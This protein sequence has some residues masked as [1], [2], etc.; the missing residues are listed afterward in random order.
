MESRLTY[1]FKCL[2]YLQIF[3]LNINSLFR[4]QEKNHLELRLMSME[5]A[6]LAKSSASPKT[7]IQN[8]RFLAVKSNPK[9]PFA[10]ATTPMCRE[11]HYSFTWIALL[12]LDP[13]LKIQSIKQRGIKYLFLLFGMTRPEI[14]PQSPGPLAKTLTLMPKF[15]IFLSFFRLILTS[16]EEV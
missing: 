5:W 7:T 4:K 6:S 10:L 15:L 11:G 14:E 3:T 13:Y 12:T 2:S 16:F 9:A 1:I 8:E